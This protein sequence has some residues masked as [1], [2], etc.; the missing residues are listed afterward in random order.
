MT[1][2]ELYL[3][4]TNLSCLCKEN[5]LMDIKQIPMAHNAAMWRGDVSSMIQEATS[6]KK[7]SPW[8]ISMAPI[9]GFE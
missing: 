2:E 4:N 3:W 5:N 6:K 8:L 7:L 1:Q 9:A